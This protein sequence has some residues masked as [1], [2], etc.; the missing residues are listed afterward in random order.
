MRFSILVFFFT[1]VTFVGFSQN[2]LMGTWQGILQQAGQPMEKSTLIYLSITN[3]GVFESYTREEIYDTD[4]Y[5]VKKI[6]GKTDKNSVVFDQI[7]VQ[8]SKQSGNIKWCRFKAELNYNENTGYLEGEYVS[9]DC[10]RVMGTIKLYSIDMKI[11]TDDQRTISQLWFSQ[12]QKDLKAGLNAPLIRKKERD[13]FVFE[14][15][16]FDYDESFLRV[17]HYDFLDRMIKIIKGHSDLRVKV[18]GH[19]DADGS[20][21]YNDELSK[22][23]AQ[24]I[25]DYFVQQGLSSDRLVFDFKGEKEPVDTN[26]TPE[27]KQRNRRVDFQFI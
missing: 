11:S 27:G 15:V 5:A 6:K 8:K 19:T 23:R 10:K 17:E 7:V 14:P 2:Q 25:V 22:R 4:A 21:A 20:D 1:T 16:Y 18:T 26:A 24:A 12:F 9:T 13:N 3:E